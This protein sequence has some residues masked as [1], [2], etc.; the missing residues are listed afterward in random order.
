VGAQQVTRVVIDTN[1]V[2][3]ALLFGGTPG[4][5]IDCW[6][7]GRIQPFASPTIVEEYLRV[8]AYPRFE[9]SEAEIEYLLYR[10]VL[11]FFE[12]G[13]PETGPAVIPEDPSD[14]AFLY[15]AVAARACAIISG[16]H[17]L[18]DLG[19]FRNIPIVTAAQF[20]EELMQQ[21]KYR[22]HI[23]SRD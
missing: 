12:P 15:C 1:V 14:D 21:G 10:Q 5:L 17:H 19:N 6:R 7:T 13:D 18:L 9:L 4:R 23:K 11:A 2:V 16:D 8:L 3:S 22:K 20:L